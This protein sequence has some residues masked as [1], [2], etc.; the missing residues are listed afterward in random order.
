M[1]ACDGQPVISDKG[2]VGQGDCRV[3]AIH[4]AVF[5][6]ICDTTHALP[7]Q[8]CAATI[9]RVIASGTGCTDDLQLGT[10]AEQY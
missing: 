9:I 1:T 2:V 6:L 7:I 5:P 10:T 3:S 8:V 4:P